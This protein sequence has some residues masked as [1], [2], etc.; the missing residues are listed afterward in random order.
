MKSTN[1]VGRA[2]NADVLLPHESVSEQHAEIR[3]DGERWILRDLGS[4]N[5]CII[6]GNHLR[7]SEMA[8]QRNALI[9]IGSLHVIFL[10]VDRERAALDSRHEDRALRLL[11]QAGRVTR[12]EAAQIRRLT[13][14]DHNQ[15][16]AEILL[17]ETALGPVEWANAIA[18]ARS[19]RSMLERILGLFGFGK[20]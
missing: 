2:E 10:C 12:D 14:V 6:D 18:M 17:N 4:T 20:R 11:V 15:S 3:F 16:V 19:H 9:G 8:M 7:N 13:R 1:S 5:G